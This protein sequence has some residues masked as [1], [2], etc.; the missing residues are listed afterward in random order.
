MGV[1]EAYA[2]EQ[3]WLKT[4]TEGYDSNQNSRVERRNEKLAAGLRLMLFGA[5]G[6]RL[7]YE[8]LWGVGMTHMADMIN[9]LPEAG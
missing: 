7:Y 9:H 4:T 3:A 6:G 5:T 1:V 8:E 2:Q